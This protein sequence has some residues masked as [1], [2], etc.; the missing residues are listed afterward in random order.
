MLGRFC[1]WATSLG[2]GL[3][4]AEFSSLNDWKEGG[5]NTQARRELLEALGG[6]IMR[7]T[8]N[9]TPIL[10]IRKPRHTEVRL[11]LCRTRAQQQSPH[12]AAASAPRRRHSRFPSRGN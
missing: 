10:Q 8:A 5:P 7:M 3:N 4:G 2:V 9:S 12:Q 6:A 11:A 1:R